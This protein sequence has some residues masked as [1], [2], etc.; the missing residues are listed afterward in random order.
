MLRTCPNCGFQTEDD[1]RKTCIRCREILPDVTY[2]VCPRCNEPIPTPNPK[3]CPKCL[4]LLNKHYTPESKESSGKQIMSGLWLIIGLISA[5][6]IIAIIYAIVVQF[7]FTAENPYYKS[8]D[9]Y[10][11]HYCVDA[12]GV[13]YG[14]PPGYYY[15]EVEVIQHEIYNGNGEMELTPKKQ[16]TVHKINQSAWVKFSDWPSCKLYGE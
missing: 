3:Y 12:K 1:E 8:L 2:D 14:A 16:I 7:F 13:T 9:L 4:I 15:D 11:G 6:I 10:S 5:L